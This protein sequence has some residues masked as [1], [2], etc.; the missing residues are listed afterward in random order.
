ME[1]FAAVLIVQDSPSY[2]RYSPFE[3][4]IALNKQATVMCAAGMYDSALEM[5]IMPN[6]IDR[7]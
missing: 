7:N 1:D 3:A 6:I 2:R 5:I 4:C